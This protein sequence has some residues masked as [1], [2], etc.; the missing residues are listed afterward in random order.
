MIFPVEI[1]ACLSL[2]IISS[3]LAPVKAHSFGAKSLSSE[4]TTKHPFPL[5]QPAKDFVRGNSPGTPQS[6]S[7][8]SHWTPL[9]L[10]LPI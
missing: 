8:L 10:G 7:S 9:R 5:D 1:V 3:L 6:P 4:M 2:S